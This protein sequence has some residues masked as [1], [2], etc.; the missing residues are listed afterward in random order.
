MGR[1]RCLIA[2]KILTYLQNNSTIKIGHICDSEKMSSKID[3]QKGQGT[4][5]I[6][7]ESGKV[8]DLNDKGST[9][10]PFKLKLKT[11]TFWKDA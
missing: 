10:L 11:I 6:K 7:P 9:F 3:E 8:K 1:G 4:E 5:E 2:D